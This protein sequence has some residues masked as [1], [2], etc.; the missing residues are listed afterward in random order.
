MTS[1]AFSATLQAVTTTKLNELSKKRAL[2][3]NQKSIILSKTNVER[4]NQKRLALLIEGVK[5]CFAVRTAARKRGDRRGGAGR[6]VSGS[7]KDPNLEVLLRNI[8]RFLDQS[9]YDPS[10]SSN[11]VLDW[12]ISLLK[13][14]DIQSLK[15]E[16]ATLYGKMVTEWL[17]AEKSA[18]SEDASDTPEGFEKINRAEKDEARSNWEKLVFEPHDTDPMAISEYLLTLF[19]E[20]SENKQP[21]KALHALWRSVKSFETTMSAPDQFN[22]HVLQWTINGLLASGLLSEEKRAVLKDFLASPVILT[23]V[24]DVLNMRISSIATWGWEDEVSI[25]QRRHVT[26]SYHSMYLTPA[27]LQ[28]HGLMFSSIYR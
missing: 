12:E 15:Y 13:K 23:E 25:E 11:L 20:N 27:A 24:A 14:L 9:R 8:E 4:D 26:G 10:I 2:Y 1:S 5:K 22:N 21:F 28:N 7:T 18:A 16:Y 3:E 19:G 6:I 17:K